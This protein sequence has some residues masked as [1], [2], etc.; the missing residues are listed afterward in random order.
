MYFATFVISATF[1]TTGHRDGRGRH[2]R[3]HDRRNPNDRKPD[4]RRAE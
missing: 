1:A 4:G 3:H 2:P